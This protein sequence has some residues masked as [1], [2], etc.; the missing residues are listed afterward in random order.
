MMSR[1][2]TPSPMSL[3]VPARALLAAA[4]SIFLSSAQAAPAAHEVAKTAFERKMGVVTQS[5]KPTPVPGL[6][7]VVVDRKVMYADKNAN[8]LVQGD[9]IDLSKNVNLTLERRNE[10]MHVD[11]AQLPKNG[12]VKT[13]NGSGSRVLYTFEDPN[14]GFC[15]RLTPQLAQVKDVTIITYPVAILGPDSLI[16]SQHTLCSTDPEKTWR[17]H[18]TGTV[19]G[20][21]VDSACSSLP[22]VDRNSKL[23]SSLGFRGTPAIIFADGT[24]LPGYSDTKTI[25]AR[26]TA[27]AKKAG[28]GTH[29]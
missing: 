12:L 10:L 19:A 23:M 17:Q 1:S 25:E 21:G 5:V 27:A 29:K 8:F 18:M 15:K 28:I 6:F 20:Y 4:A 9:I 7:E 26:L 11:V 2:A 14:C 3:L 22:M 24:S 16:R 13:V